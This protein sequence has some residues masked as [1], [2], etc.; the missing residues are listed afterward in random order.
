MLLLA[1][2]YTLPLT[3]IATEGEGFKSSVW[4]GKKTLG[5]EDTKKGLKILTCENLL[6]VFLK[7][8][9]SPIYPNF[10][11]KI[12]GIHWTYKIAQRTLLMHYTLYT[13]YW[14]V[15]LKVE[16]SVQ[17]RKKYLL[18]MTTLHTVSQSNLFFL[19]LTNNN[20]AQVCIRHTLS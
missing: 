16:W 20:V 7:I 2:N 12:V 10:C 17:S 6:T 15:L 13:S 18:L 14:E 1:I 3:I 8:F 9:L 19:Q 4:K 5:L 11:V